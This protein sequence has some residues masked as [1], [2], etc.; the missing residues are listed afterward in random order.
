MKAKDEGRR[1]KYGVWKTKDEQGRLG[2]QRTTDGGLTMENGGW[3][4]EDRA[5]GT[6]KEE[7]RSED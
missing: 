3:K 4:T 5:Q 7:P 6:E 2:G 1:T